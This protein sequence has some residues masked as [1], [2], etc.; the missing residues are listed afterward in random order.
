[1]DDLPALRSFA[2]NLHNDRAAITAGL[3]QVWSSGPTEGQINRIK[4]LK[5]Q[6][7]RRAGFALL[8]KRVLLT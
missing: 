1:A 6:M 8:R 2:G 5:R 3:T 4:T 7:Y